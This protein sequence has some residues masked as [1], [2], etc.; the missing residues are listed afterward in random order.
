M[1][2]K[3]TPGFCLDLIRSSRYPSLFGL[4]SSFPVSFRK[5]AAESG[6]IPFS[7]LI[8]I[9]FFSF[10]SLFL[11]FFLFSSSS[12][13]SRRISNYFLNFL[14]FFVTV[15]IASVPVTRLSPV[16]FAYC[17]VLDWIMGGNAPLSSVSFLSLVGTSSFTFSSD[18]HTSLTPCP[19]PHPGR[20]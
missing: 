5:G 20:S 7:F 3:D 2:E 16:S 14:W 1:H 6:E 13:L 15:L 12:L 11:R 8:I 17:Q 19:H 4:L 18:S 9:C 10:L